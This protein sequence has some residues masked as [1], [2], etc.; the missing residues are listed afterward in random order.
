M[1]EGPC[2]GEMNT[3][4]VWVGFWRGAASCLQLALKL[5]RKRVT[6]MKG[7]DSTWYNGN[8]QGIRQREYGNTLYYSCNFSVKLKVIS[9]TNKSFLEQKHA[10]KQPLPSIRRAQ[11]G[12]QRTARGMCLEWHLKGSCGPNAWASQMKAWSVRQESV[13]LG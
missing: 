11:F 9:V 6:I 5:F 1:P 13:V 7:N 12:F 4:V 3:G 10:S 2:F 8:N